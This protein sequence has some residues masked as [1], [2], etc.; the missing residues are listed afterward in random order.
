M[1]LYNPASGGSSYP[2][3]SNTT[4]ITNSY[5]VGATDFQ[6]LCNHT[7]PINITLPAPAAGRVLLVKDISGAA[8]TNNI[9]L[10]R[11]ASESIEGQAASRILQ[12]NWGE[13][14][15]TS[16]GTNWYFGG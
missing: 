1:P 7:A 11:H 14:Q 8:E 5:S 3:S 16:D 2:T 10:V 15:I 13:W 12:A 4:T 6:I 9:T